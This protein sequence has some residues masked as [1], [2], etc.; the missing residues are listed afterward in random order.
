MS[1][2]SLSQKNKKS[3]KVSSQV[4]SSILKSLTL[5]LCRL[6]MN[7]TLVKFT[8]NLVKIEPEFDFEIGL[9]T[10]QSLLICTTFSRRFRSEFLIQ[11]HFQE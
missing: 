5:H 9:Y 4:D 11:Q 6:S 7:L 1:Y 3:E 10:V 2:V 8:L